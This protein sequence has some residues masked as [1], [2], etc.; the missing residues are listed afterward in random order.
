MRSPRLK[1]RTPPAKRDEAGR[2]ETRNGLFMDSWIPASLCVTRRDEHGSADCADFRRWDAG[3]PSITEHWA[4]FL[5]FRGF[6][7]SKFK[8]ASPSIKRRRMGMKRGGR[9]AEVI[10]FRQAGRHEARSAGTQLW[11]ALLP[12]L[13]RF[14]QGSLLVHSLLGRPW[15]H[16]QA[17]ASAN[18]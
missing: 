13:R 10:R 16:E 3:V 5:S 14:W 2:H 9:D 12:G 7:A 4:L 15:L 6:M 1:I 8:M 17:N 18:N 11:E